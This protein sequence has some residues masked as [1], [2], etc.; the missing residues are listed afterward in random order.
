MTAVLAAAHRLTQALARARAYL[1]GRQC[2]N[3]GFSFYRSDVLEEPDTHD[4][5]HALAALRCLGTSPP[6][7]QDIVRFVA[8]QPVPAQPYGLYFRV[9]SL[10]LLDAADPFHA[11]VREAVA[12]LPTPDL[13]SL[14]DSTDTLYSL[15]LALWLKRH[16][17]LAFPAQD[18]ARRLLAGEHPDGGYGLPPNL[19]ATRQALAV[20]DLCQAPA[21]ARAGAF[22]MGLA[23]PD[24]ALTVCW[25]DTTVAS[26]A[27]FQGSGTC[28]VT[29]GVGGDQLVSGSVN[30]NTAPPRGSFAAAK[31]PRCRSTMP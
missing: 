29:A 17:G 26:A 16:F 19:L 4:T 11:A 3:G 12:A 10:C 22:V 15:R 9:R 20:L 23:T 6:R 28:A 31:V 24:R 13:Q 18:I 1:L 21:P 7:R 14:D 30:V 8:Q 25:K 5:W 27:S 2:A